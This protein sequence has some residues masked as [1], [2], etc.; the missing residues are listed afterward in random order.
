MKKLLLIGTIL[1]LMFS[2]CT[3][4]AN[5]QQWKNDSERIRQNYEQP[6]NV[7]VTQ[8]TESPAFN[9][10]NFANLVKKTTDPKALEAAINATGNDVN[11]LDLN[12]DMSIDYLTVDEAAGNKLIVNDEVTQGNKK[13]IATLTISGTG[14]NGTLNVQSYPQYGGSN[15]NYQSSGISVGDI[16]LMHYLL[17]PHSYYRPMYHYGY[18]PSSYSKRSVTKSYT[19]TKTVPKSSSSSSVQK[20]SLN[21][22]KSQRQFQERTTKAPINSSGFRKT[23][24]SSSSSY[25]PFRSSSSSRSSFG[26]SSRSSFGSSSRKK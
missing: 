10:T 22:G 8:V 18:Y 24:G 20:S 14:N 6:V 5:E 12:N 11:N 26:S 25:K 21:N 23:G 9:V 2:S 13:E 3:D 15:Y 17:T 16:L 4:S 7:E 1:S 19:T